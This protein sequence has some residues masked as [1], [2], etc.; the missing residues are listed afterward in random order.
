MYALTL[1]FIHTGVT[2]GVVGAVIFLFGMMVEAAVLRFIMTLGFVPV[3]LMGFIAFTPVGVLLIEHVIGV[4]GR[5]QVESIRVLQGFELFALVMPWLDVMNGLVFV[6]GQTK[7]II[8]FQ[9][10]N[11]SFTFIT[12]LVCIALAPEWNGTFGAWA[13]SIGMTAELIFVALA[14]R[15]IKPSA[16]VPAGD[17]H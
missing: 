3:L 10:A 1:Y 8:G 6:R 11:F 5:L 17:I 16:P 7:L 15:F 13:Q 9:I 4:H 2:S 14:L 12:L